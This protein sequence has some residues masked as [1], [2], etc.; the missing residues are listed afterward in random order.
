MQ[1][2]VCTEATD[3]LLS[4]I[5]ME[6]VFSFTLLVHADSVVSVVSHTTHVVYCIVSR[7]VEVNF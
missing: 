7:N 2:H 5:L 4:Y 6:V 1:P 3:S